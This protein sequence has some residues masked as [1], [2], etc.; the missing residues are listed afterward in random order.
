MVSELL[1]YL[2]FFKTSQL[3]VLLLSEIHLLLL[4]RV[5]AVSTSSSPVAETRWESVFSVVASSPLSYRDTGWQWALSLSLIQERVRP[6]PFVQVP[7]VVS[8]YFHWPRLRHIAL[9]LQER[10]GSKVCSFGTQQ[11]CAQQ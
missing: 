4:A 6:S 3:E 2:L 10:L 1:L 7:C 5:V 8:A 9:Q 11:P